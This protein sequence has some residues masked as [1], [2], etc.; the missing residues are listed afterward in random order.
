MKENTFKNVSIICRGHRENGWNFPSVTHKCHNTNLGTRSGEFAVLWNYAKPVIKQ[1][2]I[3]SLS[4]YLYNYLV[5]CSVLTWHC[6]ILSVDVCT[7]ISSSICGRL[8]RTVG[9]QTLLLRIFVSACMSGNPGLYCKGLKV[10]VNYVLVLK[11]DYHV[12][13][14]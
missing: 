7:F 3:E 8:T 14:S 11:N 13:F 5:V 4:I 12:T 2:S 10:P 1:I 6:V 9:S